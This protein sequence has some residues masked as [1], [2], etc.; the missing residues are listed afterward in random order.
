M[1]FELKWEKVGV[2]VQIWSLKASMQREWKNKV[3]KQGKSKLESAAMLDA[4]Q[5]LES[6]LALVQQHSKYTCA[7]NSHSAATLQ[8]RIV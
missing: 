3:K 2:K 4:T 5:K 1:Q 7:R 6:K 8:H